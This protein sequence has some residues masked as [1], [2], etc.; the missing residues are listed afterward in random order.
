M[1]ACRGIRPPGVACRCTTSM[2]F[3][4]EIEWDPAHM[5]RRNRVDKQI[6]VIH[7]R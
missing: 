4:E 5:V 3:L 7:Q 2:F 1:T 6:T